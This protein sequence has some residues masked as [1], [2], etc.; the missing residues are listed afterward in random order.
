MCRLTLTVANSNSWFA[1]AE[2]KDEE[3]QRWYNCTHSGETFNGGKPDVDISTLVNVTT[4]IIQLE[5]K[6]YRTASPEQ[7]CL[8]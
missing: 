8:L 1:T 7:N 2:R 4:V 3:R 6:S 5:D